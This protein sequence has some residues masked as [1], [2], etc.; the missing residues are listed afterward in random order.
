M[1]YG[2]TACI[3]M[4]LPSQHILLFES[5]KLNVTF[6][7]ILPYSI[8]VSSLLTP[9]AILILQRQLCC[10]YIDAFNLPSIMEG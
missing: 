9:D 4:E 5:S 10:S 7:F 6:F 8:S 2:F 1:A 3:Q